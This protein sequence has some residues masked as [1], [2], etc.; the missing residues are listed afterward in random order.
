MKNTG[1]LAFGILVLAAGPEFGTNSIAGR[2]GNVK[3]DSKTGQPFAVVELFTSE[4]CSSCPPADRLLGEILHDAGRKQQRIFVLAFHVDY[5]DDIGWKDPYAK[6]AY[7][8]R[9]RQ[10]SRVF[11]SSQIYTPQMI[12]NGE[13]EFVGSNRSHATSAIEWALSQSPRVTVNLKIIAVEKPGGAR[14]FYEV[15]PSHP[16]GVL[17]LAI[18]E[19]DLENDIR[20][21]ENAGRVLHHDNVV[22]AFKTVNLK[23]V[24]SGDISLEIP[25][26]MN[27]SKSAIIAYVQEPSTMEILG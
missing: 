3:S 26:E 16:A 1:A 15:K 12:V 9:Q 6:R 27:L 14:L 23:D 24:A 7:S 13:R 11:R 21:G 22:R 5:W 4:G 17:N 8:D 10:Y 20:R 25:V 18:V 19:R 2:A